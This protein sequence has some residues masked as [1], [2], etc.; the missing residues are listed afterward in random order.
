VR[1]GETHKGIQSKTSSKPWRLD[2]KSSKLFAREF[3][4]LFR[5]AQEQDD[6]RKEA[7]VARRHKCVP[8]IGFDFAPPA[9]IHFRPSARE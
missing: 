8:W 2:A 3:I 4:F 6:R 9:P 7:L 5:S 1:H